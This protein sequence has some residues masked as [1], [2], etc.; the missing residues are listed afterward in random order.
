MLIPFFL[1]VISSLGGH[2]NSET[3]VSGEGDDSHTRDCDGEGEGKGSGE[4]CGCGEA[5]AERFY[6]LVGERCWHLNCLRCQE[7]K[8]A[9]NSELSCY[10]KE[11]AVY[12]KKDY[13]R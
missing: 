6:L 7:C 9:L 2:D 1:Q 3:S 4:C 8:L 10:V 12:C 13:F 5:I 11:G